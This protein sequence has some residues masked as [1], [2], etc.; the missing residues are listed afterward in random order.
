MNIGNSAEQYLVKA[1]AAE[2]IADKLAD[3]FLRRSWLDIAEGYR[4]LA[5]IGDGFSGGSKDC[6]ARDGAEGNDHRNHQQCAARLV[7]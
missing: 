1:A 3:G 2:A 7:Q 5:G 4:E 6:Q